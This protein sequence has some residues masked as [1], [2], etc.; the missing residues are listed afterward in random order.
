MWVSWCH[1]NDQVWKVEDYILLNTN[2][3]ILTWGTEHVL[4]A[5]WLHLPAFYLPVNK[6]SVLPDYSEFPEFTCIS[7]VPYDE[8]IVRGTESSLKWMAVKFSLMF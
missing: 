3:I 4:G 7:S 2:F 8:M 1:T 5:C 6:H